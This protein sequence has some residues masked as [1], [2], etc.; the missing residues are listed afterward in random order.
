MALTSFLQLLV[1][2]SLAMAAFLLLVMVGGLVFF[3]WVLPYLAYR[4]LKANGFSGPK[5]NFPFGNLSDMKKQMVKKMDRSSTSSA[6][7]IISNDIHSTAFPYFAHWQKL[8]GK[9]LIYWLGTEPFLYIADPEFLKRVSSDIKGKSWGKPT[10]FKNDRKPMFGNGLVMV[11]GED[12]VRHR[13]V[14]TPAFSPTNLKA[15]ASLMVDSATNMLNRWAAQINSG[16]PEID[17]E[18]EIISTAG[19]IIAKSSFGISYENGRKVLK[20]LR[21]MQITLFK[22]T[23]YVGVPFGKFLNPKETLKAKALGKEIDNLLRLIIIERSNKP[24]SGK[25]EQ[26]LLGLLLAENM[27]DGRKK[28]AL[29]TKELVD[30]CKT[31]FFG[32]HE[33]TALALTWTLLLLAIHPEW[34]K[35]L[36]EEIKEVIGDEGISATKLGGLKKMGWVMNEVLRLYPPA[37]NVQR[38]A[39]QDIQVDNLVIPNGTNMWIDVVSMHHDEKLWG[40]DVNEFKPERFHDDIFGGCN[41]KMGFLPFGFGGRM[42]VGRNLTN[43]EYKIVL[44]LILSRFSFT[45]SPNYCHAPSILLSLRPMHGLPLI[46][47]PL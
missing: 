13:H 5:P 29:T 8:H 10:V 15:M 1:A 33:T 20:K 12:W 47:K 30:E 16:Q 41:H 32:G 28:R 45:L 11:E 23:R 24:P 27:V 2:L 42:C 43:M 3:W 31:F 40:K 37:P 34:Q 25:A 14:I 4:K 39:R 35:L 9:V 17:V 26:D 22:S 38:Q 46:F 7:S 18:R 21:E 6:L 36:R 19:E 44:T